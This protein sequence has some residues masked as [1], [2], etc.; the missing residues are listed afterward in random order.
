MHIELHRDGPGCAQAAGLRYVAA[1]EAGIRRLKRGEAFAY[2]W[3]DGRKVTGD[4]LARCVALVI[5]P[6]WTDVWICATPDGHIQ[7]TGRDAKG[8]KQYRYH[9]QWLELRAGIK[10]ER[11]LRFGEALPALRD[12]VAA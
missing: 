10:Y 4:H 7:A 9:A 5:P 6:A 1:D 2:R 11:L 12:R 8:R 3:P